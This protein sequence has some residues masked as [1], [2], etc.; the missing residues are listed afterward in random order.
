MKKQ[1]LVLFSLSLL[2]FCLMAQDNESE[3]VFDYSKTKHEFAVDMVPVFGGDVPTSIFYRK[4]YQ[5]QNG[6]NRGFRMNL[7]F[8]NNTTDL[9]ELTFEEGLY[10]RVS[11]HA[12]GITL[13]RETQKAIGSNF[14]AYGGTDAGFTYTSRRFR[15]AVDVGP[16]VPAVLNFHT[17][18]YNLTPFMGIKYHFNDRLSVF[19]ESGFEFFYNRF[20]EVEVLSSTSGIKNAEIADNFGTRLIPLRAL[21]IAYHF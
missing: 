19:A 2:P 20:R 17:F 11:N 5:N 1:I 21:S 12:Y 9:G 4:N 13:G 15:R 6:K 7:I 3:T 10:D 14:V 18:S 16:V 8:G